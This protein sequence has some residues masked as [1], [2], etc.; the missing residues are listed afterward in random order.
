MHIVV[1]SASILKREARYI[2]FGIFASK[3]VRF[4]RNM[5]QKLRT[6]I[7]RSLKPR[8]RLRKGNKSPMAKMLNVVP[9]E[10]KKWHM[11]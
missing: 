2:R 11:N 9:I 10:L 4:P 8:I 3:M 1:V 5:E 6:T 7:K